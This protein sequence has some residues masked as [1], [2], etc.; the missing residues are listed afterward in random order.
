[1]YYSV[2]CVILELISKETEKIFPESKSKALVSIF[3]LRFFCPSLCLATH[4]K[5]E[6]V[7][8]AALII[9]K[10]MQLLVNRSHMEE[11]DYENQY[12][13]L[14]NDFFKENVKRVEKISEILTNQKSFEEARIKSEILVKI[15]TQNSSLFNSKA[16]KDELSSS[17]LEESEMERDDTFFEDSISPREIPSPK[18]KKKNKSGSLDT[19]FKDYEKK[20]SLFFL[21]KFKSKKN[22]GQLKL[23][24]V[25]DHKKSLSS[26]IYENVDAI[27]DKLDTLFVSKSNTDEFE[28]IN[29]ALFRIHRLRSCNKKVA[30]YFKKKEITS[31]RKEF[32]SPKLV[33]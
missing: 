15:E 29:T 4:K 32:P 30:S 3:F 5:P 11:T 8:R 27:L 23:A 9:S 6:K 17:S 31:K 2:F 13:N 1:M 28:Q 22:F 24:E 21:N 16:E 20:N 14:F 7:K 18:L 25:P 26:F 10:V 33:N 19:I 12:V